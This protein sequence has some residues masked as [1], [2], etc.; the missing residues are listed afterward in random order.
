MTLHRVRFDDL[1]PQPWRNGGGVT[2]ALLTW[3]HA[4]DWAVRVSVADITRDGPFS[5]FAVEQAGEGSVVGLAVLVAIVPP[6]LLGGEW[7]VWVYRA[8][9]LLLIGCPCALV[10]SVPASIAASLSTGARQGL[11]MK[12]GVVIS[13]GS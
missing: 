10:I 6:L 8:L 7:S 13:R 5:A 11:L 9:A 1:P 2:R 12:G 4:D 3:P